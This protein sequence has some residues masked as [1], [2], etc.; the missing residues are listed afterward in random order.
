MAKYTEM[1]PKL[2]YNGVSIVDI[3][4]RFNMLDSVKEFHAHFYEETI[5]EGATAETVSF[6]LYGTHDNWW[7]IYAINNVID[8]FYDWLLSQTEL[9]EYVNKMYDPICSDGVSES[10]S[11][12]AEADG[13][14]TLGEYRIHHWEDAEFTQFDSNNAEETLLPVTNHEW[15][16]YVNDKKRRISVI[17]P[18]FVPQ[19]E[20]ELKTYVRIMKKGQAAR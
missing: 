1:L 14:W 8:P 7:L 20:A 3:T 17:H 13:M 12:C 9:D 6:D 5:A 2:E 16:T 18:E 11:A 15:E 10:E 4:H 19:I